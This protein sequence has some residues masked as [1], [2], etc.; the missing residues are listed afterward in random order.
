MAYLP[1]HAPTSLGY[2]PPPKKKKP[3]PPT[4]PTGS[5]DPSNS[6]GGFT[7]QQVMAMTPAQ[8]ANLQFL[9]STQ[10]P[11]YSS[12]QAPDFES[13]QNAALSQA[14]QAAYQQQ[15][16][17][18][19]ERGFQLAR[20]K[21]SNEAA[22]NFA[23]AFGSILTGGLEG[24]A[25][26]QYSLEHYGGSY[27]G[28]IAARMGQQLIMQAG[29]YFNEQDFKLAGQLAD[30]LNQVPDQAEKLYQ[31]LAD[32]A[33]ELYKQNASILDADHA[34]KVKALAALI[35]AKQKQAGG[36]GTETQKVGGSL[37]EKDPK[38]GKWVLK[39]AAPTATSSS[40]PRIF[41]TSEGIVA[42][43][44]ATGQV[45]WEKKTGKAKTTKVTT[46]VIPQPDGSR[47][48]I[49]KATGEK[50]ATVAPPDP[51]AGDTSSGKPPSPSSVSS[52]VAR[53][54]DAGTEALAIVLA[55]IANN[56]PGAKQPPTI[57]D[58]DGNEIPNPAFERAKAKYGAWLKSGK[59]FNSAMA[60]VVSAITPHLAPIGYS[61]NQIRALAY[62]IVSARLT[63]PK[64]YKPPKADA[65]RV[66]ANTLPKT[67]GG[68]IPV[69]NEAGRTV[70]KNVQ[71]VLQLANKYL[72]VKYVWG[73]ETPAGFDC[74]GFV[75]YLYKQVGIDPGGYTIAQWQNP[76]GIQIKSQSD[77][78]PG[79]VVFFHWGTHP[80]TG[81]E[82]PLHEGLYIGNGLF[83][84]APRTGDV[85]KIS[86]MSERSD[87]LGARRFVQAGVG[88]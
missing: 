62:T 77:L 38:T 48:L 75:R 87:F 82:G 78:Q 22:T 68:N 8:L 16:P 74:S 58:A 49:N 6:L 81:Q 70:P 57:K 63:P 35:A 15:Q 4:K 67:V 83:V 55:K 26:Q 30:V 17:I 69:V 23:K 64:G 32:S 31:Q 29:D 88:A 76:N 60:R 37:Y 3:K 5:F 25:G 44:E 86:K 19:N 12:L 54:N 56:F 39:I 21:V 36:G 85:V 61:K 10:G 53:A 50:I 34:T 9:V 2:T 71:T 66:A 33:V 72:G 13:L 14:Q 24:E 47:V 46:Q 1:G 40:K 28:G 18:Q 27:L 42:I 59:S 43:N 52:T 73:G 7:P 80:E 51:N 79:D 41:Q 20:Q 11:D 84:Q 65:A 45:V